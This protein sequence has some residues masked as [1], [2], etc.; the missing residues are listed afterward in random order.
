MQNFKQIQK[1][2]NMSIFFHKSTRTRNRTLAE[3][4]IQ[5]GGVR[6]RRGT[7]EQANALKF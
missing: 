7:L 2:Y 4:H 5:A 6:T 1:I 3:T